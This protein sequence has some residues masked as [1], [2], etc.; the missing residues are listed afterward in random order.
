MVT[1]FM[2]DG[3]I[4][5][6][7]IAADRE[8]ERPSPIFQFRS[9]DFRAVYI[10]FSAVKL[11]IPDLRYL[12]TIPQP[13]GGS[14]L[15]QKRIEPVYAIGQPVPVALI[16]GQTDIH[17]DLHARLRRNKSPDELTGHKEFYIEM[18]TV[19]PKTFS[20][21]TAT[22]NRCIITHYGPVYMGDVDEL[23]SETKIHFIAETCTDWTEIT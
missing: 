13:N 22:V 19:C 14:L 17:G 2:R 21:Y 8:R 4:N 7:E 9:R 1:S 15:I 10:P 16:R 11:Y 12:L 3:R 6:W 20:V 18:R 5:H 23:H